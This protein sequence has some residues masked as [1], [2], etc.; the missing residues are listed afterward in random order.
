MVSYIIKSSKI[1]TI[2]N[3]KMTK[4]SYMRVLIITSL[5]IALAACGGGGGSG[6][7][8][9]AGTPDGINKLMAINDQV[10]GRYRANSITL[11]EA[12]GKRTP[13]ASCVEFT[14]PTNAEV[15]AAADE[16]F[17]NGAC[18]GGYSECAY[19]AGNSLLTNT[20]ADRTVFVAH[21]NGSYSETEIFQTGNSMSGQFYSEAGIK[22]SN[23][24]TG[25]T[26]VIPVLQGRYE[27][28][29]YSVDT[30]SSSNVLR[31]ELL[32]SA[33]IVLECLNGFCNP[34]SE[35]VIYDTG[36]GFDFNPINS[37]S[38]DYILFDLSTPQNT[39][40]YQFWGTTSSDGT[41]VTGLAYPVGTG[42]DFVDCY[43][44]GCF[45]LAFEK[46]SGGQAAK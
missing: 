10:T 22:D 40:D 29:A 20:N 7:S 31:Q 14:R 15:E 27:G 38:G 1:R 46:V 8:A 3:P 37:G 45:T 36:S 42:A 13:M 11:N 44:G 4:E 2:N 28:Y 23:C 35:D 43:N 19:V 26:V 24:T 9:A 25:E 18:F 33:K 21:S 32:R 6:G 39:Q 16:V 41:V 5:T 12:D 30:L 34:I 17:S